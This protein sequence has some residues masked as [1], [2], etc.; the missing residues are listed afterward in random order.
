MGDPLSLPEQ[1]PHDPRVLAEPAMR[2]ID[3][4]AQ[5][6]P[7]GFAAAVAEA[8]GSVDAADAVVYLADYAQR[9][10]VPLQYAGMPERVPLDVDGSV[11]GR[12]FRTMAVWD[13]E[14]PV[15]GRRRLWL[16]LTEGTERIGVLS[17]TVPPERSGP[18][19]QREVYARFAALVATLVVSQG[20]YGDLFETARRDRPMRLPAE[21]QWRLLPPTSCVTSRVTVTG[22]LEPWDQV[23]GDAFDYAVNG[24]TVHVALF[25]AMGHGLNAT[26]LTGVA[27]GAYR[28]ARRRGLDL[29]GTYRALDAAIAAQFDRECFVTALLVEL[30][31]ATGVTRWMSAGHLPP[32]L[33]RGGGLV[34]VTPPRPSPPAGLRMSERTPDERAIQLQPG[35]RL[36][37]Y[38]D[39][40]VEARRGGE[41]F[42][43]ER[44]ADIVVSE[45]ASGHPLPEVL[46]RVIL[47]VMEHQQGQ[48]QDDATILLVEWRGGTPYGELS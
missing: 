35:D 22:M 9:R 38:T 32:L 21:I 27:V 46:R 34:R 37:L 29:A 8:A 25:D 3:A 41:F 18:D 40:V 36:L 19:W 28:N 48:L 45:S 42:T 7:H 23:G 20:R 2:L 6:G 16:P 15:P 43:D 33:L 10:L 13:G 31:L 1:A 24:D 17:L 14:E 12:A 39:G 47:R 26:V 30:D 44:L 4:V 5:S 11:G